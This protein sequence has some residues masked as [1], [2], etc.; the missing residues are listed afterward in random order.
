MNDRLLRTL[1]GEETDRRPLWIMRQAGRYLPEY[2][3]LR[4][5]HSFEALC[6]NAE[7]AAQVTLMPFERFPLDGAIVFADLMSPIPAL[8]RP[9]RFAPGPVVDNPVRTLA[10]VESLVADDPNDVGAEVMQVLSKVNDRLDGRATLL[11][12]AGAPWSISAYLVQGQGK[13]GFP[14]LRSMAFG[15]TATL[16]ALQDRLADVIIG[17]VKRQHA[18]GAQ[19]IQIFDTWAGL[20]SEAEWRSKVRP[21][22]LKILKA[23]GEAG[24]PR[25]LFLQDAAH[26]LDAYAELPSE[27]LSV[28][29]RLDLADIRERVGPTKVL[30]GNLDP[31]M[32]LAGPEATRRAATDLFKRVPKGRH[33]MNL[34]HGILPNTPIESVQALVDVVQSGL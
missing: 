3:A 21:H 23:M 19:A 13:K 15:Q 10:D 27:C 12:F 7:L 33:I 16:H 1:L 17:Y 18:A 4:A 29:W 6:A 32:L 24:I 28:D 2:R 31:A 14:E 5:Q 22:L 25:I 34:G 26:L 20:L 30:Q 11:G 9:V 8:G